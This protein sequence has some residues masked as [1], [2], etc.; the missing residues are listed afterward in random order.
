MISMLQQLW[1]I[2]IGK[3][4]SSSTDLQT[5]SKHR[6]RR[7]VSLASALAPHQLPSADGCS[8]AYMLAGLH[9][10]SQEPASLARAI[11]ESHHCAIHVSVQAELWFVE[12]RR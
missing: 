4:V 6:T 2:L 9:D 5:S 8:F 10:C 11:G 1:L 12:V 3:T 7:H